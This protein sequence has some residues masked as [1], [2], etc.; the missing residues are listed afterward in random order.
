MRTAVYISGIVVALAGFVVALSPRVEAQSP[1][2]F[3]GRPP[4]LALEGLGSA[5]GVSVR[6]TDAEEA[7]R[8]G[9]GGVVIQDVRE[10]TSASRAG[11]REGDIVVEFDGERAR[12][13]RQFTRLVRETAPG[14]A[15]KVTVVRGGNRQTLE[16][17]PEARGPADLGVLPNITGDI[18]RGLRVLPRDFAF[19]YTPGQFPDSFPFSQRRLGV[20]VTPLSDQLAAYFGVK[21][22]VLV[23]DVEAG[24]PAAAAGIKAGDVITDINGH[25]V[26]TPDDV[27]RE[28][29]GT[30]T[31]SSVEVRVTRDRQTLTFTPKLPE[32]V[33]PAVGRGRP[34]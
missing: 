21:Q 10:G 18:Q 22:G 29:R 7:R 16:I 24:S 27:V 19:D 14:R 34:V 23:S 32:P 30:G 28:M 26:T 1:A 9:T 3:A 20:R 13:A 6:D 8:A 33:R 4:F 12:S 2:P 17:T 5:I 31:G 25:A 11:L 15:V